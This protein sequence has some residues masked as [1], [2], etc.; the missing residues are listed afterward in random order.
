MGAIAN[1]K[2]NIC[3]ELHRKSSADNWL[4]SGNTMPDEM[5]SS[6]IRYHY[7]I[8]ITR[9][10]NE[11]I[12]QIENYEF[13]DL[14]PTRILVLAHGLIR[15]SPHNNIASILMRWWCV[16]QF[17][18][19]AECLRFDATV[20]HVFTARRTCSGNVACGMFT[21]C[22]LSARGIVP[23]TF[24]HSVQSVLC[25]HCVETDPRRSFRIFSIFTQSIL[26]KRN[27]FSS[28]L[29]RLRHRC[30]DSDCRQTTKTAEIFWP[31]RYDKTTKLF[32]SKIEKKEKKII[33]NKQSTKKR[34]ENF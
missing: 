2:S 6:V 1:E 17:S 14:S 33:N 9:D 8:D 11:H 20:A 30:S 19:I 5:F 3:Y 27:I 10:C 31:N 7:Y 22:L 32:L 29:S 15:H 13:F 21:F 26:R 28:C 23:T 18:G 25:A 24:E 34:D 4:Q 12:R 16:R